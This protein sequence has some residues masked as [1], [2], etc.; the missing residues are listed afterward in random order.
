M[1]LVF[2]KRELQNYSSETARFESTNPYKFSIYCLVSENVRAHYLNEFVDLFS[3][4]SS[5]IR[6]YSAIKN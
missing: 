5:A 3:S 2:Y 4:E 6:M 1:L